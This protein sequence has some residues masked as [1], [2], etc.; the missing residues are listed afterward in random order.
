MT[1]IWDFSADTWYDYSDWDR[2]MLIPI[3]WFFLLIKNLSQIVLQTI[4]REPSHL[5]HY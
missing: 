4:Q 3:V 5:V 2:L 1:P